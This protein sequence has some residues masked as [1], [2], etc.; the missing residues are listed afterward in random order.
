[1]VTPGTHAFVVELE[2]AF[3]ENACSKSSEAIFTGLSREVILTGLETI[4]RR[5]KD[6]IDDRMTRKTRRDMYEWTLNLNTLLKRRRSYLDRMGKRF[7]SAVDTDAFTDEIKA[8]VGD[9]RTHRMYD[10][11]DC[12]EV[13]KDHVKQKESAGTPRYC[14]TGEPDFDWFLKTKHT[15]DEA[16]ECVRSAIASLKTAYLSR[17]IVDGSQVTAQIN[18]WYIYCLEKKQNSKEVIEWLQQMLKKGYDF[19]WIETTIIS[20]IIISSHY[21]SEA[22]LRGKKPTKF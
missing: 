15:P 12:F 11:E 7:G 10:F 6:Y 18:T 2:G 13:P 22:K 19:L 5:Y 16:D 1:M 17:S 9:L 21:F 20:S 14:A 4:F 3:G 8:S